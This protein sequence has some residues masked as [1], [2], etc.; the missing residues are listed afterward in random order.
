MY[1]KLNN[2][3]NNKQPDESSELDC[4][5]AM[6]GRTFVKKKLVTEVSKRSESYKKTIGI[7]NTVTELSPE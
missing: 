6:S 3:H 4:D 1:D 2:K 5:I 7:L